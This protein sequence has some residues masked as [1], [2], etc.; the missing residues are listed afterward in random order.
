MRS[1]ARPGKYDVKVLTQ[2]CSVDGHAYVEIVAV[3]R[4]RL[5][6]SCRIDQSDSDT[7]IICFV[8]VSSKHRRMG[9]A[10]KMLTQAIRISAKKIGLCLNVKP[11]N[12][13]ARRLY[14]SMGFVVAYR[15]GRVRD[16]MILKSRLA[17]RG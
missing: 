3:D 12:R 9:I 16:F 10:R 6:G 11:S 1:I 8:F 4:D 14:E 7:P 13:A 17:G 2:K 15:E 5:V